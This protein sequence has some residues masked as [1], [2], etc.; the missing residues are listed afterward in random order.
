MLQEQALGHRG[1]EAE[2]G[3]SC[4]ARGKGVS[5]GDRELWPCCGADGKPRGQQHAPGTAGHPS[6]QAGRRHRPRACVPAQQ[7]GTGAGPAQPPLAA[8]RTGLWDLA[9]RPLLCQ[10]GTWTWCCGCQPLTEPSP[11]SRRVLAGGH[12][13]RDGDGHQPRTMGGTARRRRGADGH[14][15]PHAA[16]GTAG[17]QHGQGLGPGSTGD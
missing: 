6:H 10:R 13:G 15:R 14:A 5:C 8:P 9:L 3:G 16:A 4:W 12:T 7:P 11:S 1:A 2:R 17:H